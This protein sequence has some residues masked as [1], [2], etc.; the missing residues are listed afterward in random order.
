MAAMPPLAVTSMPGIVK[1]SRYSAILVP[2]IVPSREISVAI[3]A[4]TPALAQRR[5]NATP[6]SGVTSFQPLTATAPSFMSTPTAICAPYFSAI[7]AVKSKFFTAT[8][9]RMQRSAPRSRYRWMR[10][11]SRMPPPTSILRPPSLAMAAIVCKLAVVSSLA[12][13]RSTT[14]KYFA[15]ASINCCAWATGSAL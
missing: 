6:G 7:S 14:C 3:M 8:V 15:P 11:S 1:S 5:Q 10:A 13:S 4:L 2:C 9:P 12:P